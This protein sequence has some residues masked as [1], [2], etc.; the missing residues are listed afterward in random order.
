VSPAGRFLLGEELSVLD[1]YLAVVSRWS[2]RRRRFYAAAPALVPVVKA[3][4]AEPR[5]A[6][7]W[8]ARMPFEEGWEG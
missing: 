2:P 1:L 3:V 4:D 5:L 7:F 6:A 8:A